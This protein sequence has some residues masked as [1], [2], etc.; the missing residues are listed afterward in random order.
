VAGTHGAAITAEWREAET[1]EAVIMGGPHYSNL[2]FRY[3][4]EIVEP[5]VEC[6]QEGVFQHPR[7][8]DW[9]YRC[10]NRSDDVAGFYW[11]TYYQC[12]EGTVADTDGLCVRPYQGMPTPCQLTPTAP[13]PVTCGAT[14]YEDCG[15]KNIC[16]DNVDGPTLVEEV[17][18]CG[19]GLQT[20]GETTSRV[21]LCTSGELYD[22]TND[23][24][25]PE[26]TVTKCGELES[27]RE[28]LDPSELLS[29]CYFR[30]SDCNE[31]TVCRDGGASRKERLCSVSQSCTRYKLEPESL[32]CAG[33]E[34]Y[35]IDAAKCVAK[36]TATDSCEPSTGALEATEVICLSTTEHCTQQRDCASGEPF[37][38]CKGYYT[39]FSIGR[40][41]SS[42]ASCPFPQQLEP[43]SGACV[44]RSLAPQAVASYRTSDV[45]VDANFTS[46]CGTLDVDGPGA[47]YECSDVTYCHNNDTTDK[48]VYASCKNIMNGCNFDKSPQLG[49]CPTG[50]SWMPKLVLNECVDPKNVAP[51]GYKVCPEPTETEVSV[52]VTI[53]CDKEGEHA[54]FSATMLDLYCATEATCP[55]DGTISAVTE[56][57]QYWV[58]E[59]GA[60]GVLQSRKETCAPGEK[61]SP[62][63]KKCKPVVAEEEKCSFVEPSG[64]WLQL[65]QEYGRRQALAAIQQRTEGRRA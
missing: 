24:C 6:P 35:D 56:C 2:D 3:D 62:T 14:T 34:L 53:K 31:Y 17:E 54:E 28:S 20:C 26:T 29:T 57:E 51:A 61:Y 55:S 38:D 37:L 58:C 36:P 45:C 19:F 7:R 52:A 59:V 13:E 49:S 21:D 4:D 22:K 18:V 47:E 41:G 40:S 64:R 9:F 39:C 33:D 25:I 11:R 30:V 5:L 10:H 65:V 43:S 63:E 50:L 32:L 42:R 16:V 12:A 1:Q 44:H 27:P 48:V 60:D 15:N 23:Q 46:N 8:C